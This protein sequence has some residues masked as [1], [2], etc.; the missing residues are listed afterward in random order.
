MKRP[1]QGF[2]V[3]DPANV[4]PL[5]VWLGS[6]ESGDVT[7]RVFELEGGMLSVA[8]G[9][10]RG[11]RVERDDRWDPELFAGTVHRRSDR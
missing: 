8:D 11:P 7:G 2:D 3:A 1:E 6:E 4:S 10:Q 5:V 9:W